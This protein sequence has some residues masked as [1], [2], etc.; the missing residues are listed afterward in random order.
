MIPPTIEEVRA[1]AKEI[2]L[3]ELEADRCWY[4]YDSK[5]WKVGKTPMTKWRS[6]LSGWML[7]WKQ[8]NYEPDHEEGF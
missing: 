8:N 6:A 1:R 4:F 7:R 2:G 3:P 5:G